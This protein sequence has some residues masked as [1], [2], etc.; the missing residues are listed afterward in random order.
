V[1]LADGATLDLFGGAQYIQNLASVGAGSTLVIKSG[2]VIN[3][4]SQQ[5]VL[6]TNSN[7]S[8]SG[9]ITGDIYFS[10]TGGN[11]LNVGMPLA[12]TG[13]T[14][15]SGGN[16]QVL[17]QGT[18]LGTSAITLERAQLTIH[19]NT[20]VDLANRI[21]DT[22]P[23]TMK[24]GT[25]QFVGHSGLFSGET[26]GAVTLG[27]GYNYF[28]V[29]D[30]GGSTYSLATGTLTL[31]SL[32]QTA[33]S[34]AVLRMNNLGE[35]GLLGRSHGRVM[36]TS[37]PTLTNGILG[38]W[39][40]VDRIFASYD[41]VYGLG[42]ID[43]AGFPG[44]AG[45]GLN[46]A[47]LDTD[48]VYTSQTGLVPLLA[49]TAVGTLTINI[50]D[51]D[52]TY[53]LGGNTLRLRNGGLLLGE[54]NGN[55][56]LTIANGNITAGV[57]GSA[58]EL[59]L[60]HAP[61]GD[62]GRRGWVSANIVDN[63][64]AGPVR[65]IVSGADSRQLHSSLTLAGQNTNTGG[66]II[67]SSTIVLDPAS[68]LG[69]GG[70]VVNGGTLR[71]VSNNALFRVPSSVTTVGSNV[72][73]LSAGTTA[74]LAVGMPIWGVPGA[75]GNQFIT[76]ITN[77]TTYTITSGTNVT[78]ATTSL[79]ALTNAYSGNG[80]FI[81]EQS[82]QLNGSAT[83]YL[84]GANRLTSLVFENGGGNGMNLFNTGV[85]TLTS[86]IT[87]TSTNAVNTANIATG[88]LDLNAAAA[89]PVSIGAIS[90]GGRDVAPWV[91]SLV[92]NAFVQNGGITKSGNGLLQFGAQNT[93]S[94]GV[95]VTGGGLIVGA[96][97]TPISGTFTGPF[98]NGTVSMATGTRLAPS[99]SRTLS[100]SE[101]M[102]PA[103]VTP[104][105]AA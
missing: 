16:L 79:Y 14:L 32:T 89:F 17:D 69:T 5:A 54:N 53:D 72:I 83:V 38:P 31:A 82:M 19:N 91:A 35:L 95:N 4:G 43:R 94:G 7:S 71:Q 39:A 24:G 88:T 103:S 73:T 48:N 64:V 18:L 11:T 37:A 21:S 104:S 3:S 12:Y 96:N 105:L 46:S 23:I 1:V 56:L 26:V 61:Y 99:P 81:P 76:G 63:N 102:V 45:S 74:N 59:Y 84:T 28:A 50:G 8:Y 10:K 87:A 15:V 55:R 27:N 42:G 66:T 77:S 9:G 41:P 25:L 36:V 75:G 98:G 90:I 86:G 40:I 6:V 29:E 33:G 22:A 20:T 101:I 97:T 57:V 70:I 13:P 93:F 44:F 47:P 34:G 49:N 100:L 30:G 2:T 85:L 58:A 80:A 60:W 78:A 62:D 67:N 51:A 65:L 68:R 92:I 52:A